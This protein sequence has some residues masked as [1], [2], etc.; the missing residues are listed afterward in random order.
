MLTVAFR[1]SILTQKSV[2]KWYKC[3]MEGRED[4]DDDER[5]GEE[6]IEAVN[7]MV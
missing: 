4:I 3:F 5:P 1:E 2:Y 7:K 6:H